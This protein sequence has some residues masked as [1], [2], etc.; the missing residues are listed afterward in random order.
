MNVNDMDP[1]PSK[2]IAWS[3]GWSISNVFRSAL[4]MEQ[5]SFSEMI[6]GTSR[7][8]FSSLYVMVKRYLMDIVGSSMVDV[9]AGGTVGMVVG[10]SKLVDGP[11]REILSLRSGT[12]TSC[13]HPI[14]TR[15]YHDGQKLTCYASF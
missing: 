14:R 1:G 11:V 9:D 12:T 8:A 6:P 2:Q 15:V 7:A 3:F 10:T 13:Q 4:N 5:T